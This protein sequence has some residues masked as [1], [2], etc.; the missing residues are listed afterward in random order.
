M[1]DYNISFISKTTFERHVYETMEKYNKVLEAIDLERFNANIV[2][3]IKLTFDMKLFRLEAE[4]VIKN[5]IQR[6]RD[7]SD[8]NAI[9]Y[10][11]QN[12]FKYIKNCEV[13]KTGFDVIYTNPD[14]K[15]K[16]YVEMKNKYNTMNSGAAAHVYTKMLDQLGKE[17][18]SDDLYFLVEVIAPCSRNVPWTMKL[19]GVPMNNER[20]RR[21]SIDKFYAIVTGENDAFY[22][23]C[24]QLPK[25]IDELIRSGIVRDKGEDT[26]ISELESKNKD[27]LK[28]LYL[29]AFEEYNGFENLLS[30]QS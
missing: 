29:L 2:D 3:P 4:D 26:V 17:N 5:E 11:H 20:I 12:M 8:T 25:A 30:D 6:Q 18:N 28:A 13:P 7:K 1:S 24:S 21:V 9:G 27:L 23:I 16:I 22:Q 19:N 15:A 14:T 10:F